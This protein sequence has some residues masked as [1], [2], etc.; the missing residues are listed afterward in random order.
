MVAVRQVRFPFAQHSLLLESYSTL[1]LHYACMNG[2]LECA[3]ALV[4]A[5]G[6]KLVG[7]A[8]DDGNT[9]LHLAAMNRHMRTI[10]VLLQEG[11]ANPNQPNKFGQSPL[12][13]AQSK[14]DQELLA[15]F[16]PEKMVLLEKI[17]VLAE[18][19]IVFEERLKLLVHEKEIEI[20][21][22]MQ[23]YKQVSALESDLAA[24]NQR[25]SEAEERLSRGEQQYFLLQQQL[26]ATQTEMQKQNILV[27]ALQ[28]QLISAQQIQHNAL[29]QQIP[30]QHQTQSFFQNE[31]RSTLRWLCAVK[32]SLRHILVCAAEVGLGQRVARHT[33]AYA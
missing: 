3:R 15:Y 32:L 18:E 30:M 10:A 20:K 31:V 6:P 14:R 4:R 27:S 23:A 17:E 28:Q 11:G 2:H 33:P 12:G 26:Q 13:I 9:A 5:G 22:T 19:N 16:D 1:A 24:A 25:A 7:I 29:A 8:S 21:K